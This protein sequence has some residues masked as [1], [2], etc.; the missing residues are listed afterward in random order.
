MTNYDKI[1]SRTGT[2]GELPQALVDDVIGDVKTQSTIM[3][4]G[5]VITTNT[6]DSRIPVLSQDV[7]AYWIAGD[8]GLKG[9][10][11][12]QWTSTS[13]YAEELAVVC[14]V[15]D[16]V[17]DDASFPIW[18]S[19][20]PLIARAFARKLDAAAL[21]G[22]NRPASWGPSMLETATAATAVIT[23]STG[24]SAD[25]AADM[26]K[27]AE[28][29]SAQQLTPTASAVRNGYQYA[30]G[31]TRTGAFNFSPVTER[32]PWPLSLAGLP[33]ATDPVYWEPTAAQVIVADWRQCIVGV[34]KTLTF[35]M[36]KDGVIS[37]DTG[38]VITNLMT[39]DSTACRAVLRVGFLL[40][41]PVIGTNTPTVPVAIVK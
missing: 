9:T 36:H 29:V 10:S 7:D 1:V 23:K 12:A 3:A 27:A 22:T 5:H 30:A 17:V 19:L 4:L 40:K 13:L 2:G 37:D 34:R 14:P 25:P 6:A 39:Q 20:R 15:P 18:A 38:K 11:A 33:I 26:L 41:R 35:T 31:V 24:T 21:F 32:T 16:N 8:T 28:L